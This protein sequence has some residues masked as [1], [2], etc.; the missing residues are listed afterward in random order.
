MKIQ[1][2]GACVLKVFS[3]CYIESGICVYVFMREDKFV[4]A[5]EFVCLCVWSVDFCITYQSIL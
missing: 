3:I 2:L 5:H 4:G 1:Y